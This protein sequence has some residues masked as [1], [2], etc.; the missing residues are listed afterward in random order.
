MH[1]QTEVG[2]FFILIF[3][4]ITPQRNFI[5]IILYGQLLRVRFLVSDDSKVAWGNIATRA[6]SVFLNARCP[7]IV[8]TGYNK[9]KTFV[10]GL[11]HPVPPA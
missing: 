11:G 8:Q 2:V 10:H 3:Q 4:L 6:D 7:G 1:R 5:L 9:V